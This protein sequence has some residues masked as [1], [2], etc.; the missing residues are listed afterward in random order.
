MALAP[1][2]TRT[3]VDSVARFEEYE[4]A[5]DGPRRWLGGQAEKAAA[6]ARVQFALR[7]KSCLTGAGTSNSFA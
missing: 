4:S 2:S 7:H 1:I 5:I 6:K 3:G